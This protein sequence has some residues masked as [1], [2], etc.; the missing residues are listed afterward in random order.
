MIHNPN[1]E[2]QSSGRFFPRLND[3]RADVTPSMKG[4]GSIGAFLFTRVL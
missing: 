4:P 1:Q 3:G 2:L